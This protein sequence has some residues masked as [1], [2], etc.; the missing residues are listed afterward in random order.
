M[1][2]SARIKLENEIVFLIVQ[3][4]LDLGFTVEHNNGEEITAIA[5]PGEETRAQSFKRLMGEVQQCDEEYLTIKD[6]KGLR[7]GIV[8]LVYGNEGWDV[9][10]D[11]TANDQ[12]TMI[13]APAAKYIAE[14]LSDDENL[15]IA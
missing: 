13:L 6:D 7:V 1:N 11:H 5:T 8:Y 2:I 15:V 14:L 12:M 4:A 9:I 3:S 10:N